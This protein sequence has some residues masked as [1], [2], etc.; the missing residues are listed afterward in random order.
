VGTADVIGHFLSRF[1]TT[2][3]SSNILLDNAGA[4]T[5]V[6]VLKLLNL[7][8]TGRFG[9]CHGSINMVFPELQRLRSSELGAEAFAAPVRIKE[10]SPGVSRISGFSWNPGASRGN[11]G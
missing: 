2:F 9:K 8:E 3:W 10:A 1:T 6:N 5:S 4:Q 11:A 7:N